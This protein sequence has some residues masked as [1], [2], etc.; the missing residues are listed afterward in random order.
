MFI[1]EKMIKIFLAIKNTIILNILLFKGIKV[2]KTVKFRYM[3]FLKL[4]GKVENII[5]GKNVIFHGAVDL[6]NRENGKII[7]EDGVSIEDGCRFVAARDGIIKIGKNTIITNGAI[8][9][10]GGNI[11]IGSDCIFGPYNIINAN[12]HKI[13]INNFIRNKEFDYGNI[14]IGNNVWTGAFISIKKNVTIMDNSIIGA[15]S[16]VS[17]D[18]KKNSINYG[19]PCKFIKFRE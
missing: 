17:K 4:N 5:I 1:L 19:V 6:R 13:G 10:G 3:P 18:T 12:D 9:N 8:M 11:I 7:F 16:F 14:E 2:H 15:H